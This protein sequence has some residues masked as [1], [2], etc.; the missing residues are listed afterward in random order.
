M[1]FAFS[2]TYLLKNK[3]VLWLAADINKTETKVIYSVK[4][5]NDSDKRNIIILYVSTYFYLMVFDNTFFPQK[6][7]YFL[8][9]KGKS[10]RL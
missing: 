9:P 8:F 2:K 5:V 6:C 10:R 4:E 1:V 7:T 3:S